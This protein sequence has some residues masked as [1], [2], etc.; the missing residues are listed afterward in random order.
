M[1]SPIGAAMCL[2]LCLTAISVGPTAAAESWPQFRGP[3]SAGTNSAGTAANADPQPTEI[4]PDTNVVWKVDLSPGHSS[5]IVHGNRIYLTAVRDKQLLTLGLD[6]ATGKVLWEKETPHEML[7]QI[8]GIGSY[9]Q[10][11]PAT[12][13]QRVVSFFGSS[14][15]YCHDP[16]GKLLW[17]RPMGPFNNDF[18]AGSSPIMVADRII[19]CQ[20]HDQN[21][22]LMALDKRTGETIWKTDRSEFPRNY[23]TPVI[24]EVAGK[25]QIVVAATLRVVGYDFDTGRELWTVRGI[26]RLVCVTPVVGNDGVLYVAS[27]AGGGDAGERIQVGP[28][29]EALADDANKDGLLA[30]NELPKGPI[31]QRFTQVDR[32]K[33]G[34]I[35]RDEYEFFR[36]LFDQS[37]NVIMAIKPGGTGD[38]TSS[39]VLWEHTKHVPFCAS[40][41]VYRGLLFTV[42]DGGILSSYDA[43]SGKVLKQARLPA[44]GEYYSSPV[45]GDGKLYL[46]NAR[47]KL[48]VISAAGEWQVLHGADFGEDAYATPAI[49]DGKIY[50]RTTGHL[51]CFGAARAPVDGISGSR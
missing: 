2:A 51:Y 12:D 3:N 38:L 9:A 7:E 25:K 31:K 1:K 48:T 47:G 15:L 4:G 18:G 46:M 19:L 22:F 40:P 8:H 43:S 28:F 6:R 42:K 50:L 20:D 27:W 41:L 36:G 30:E 37:R 26:S 10:P 13:G 21:S 45:A 29:E 14:G 44:T 33:N 11:S 17:K 24:W 16:Q 49:V 35:T 39:N 32:D 34:A 23:C 5:P